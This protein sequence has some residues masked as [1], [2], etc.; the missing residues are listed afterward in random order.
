MC[1]TSIPLLKK[2]VDKASVQ[3]EDHKKEWASNGFSIMFDGW[4]DSVVQKVLVNFLVNSPRGSV[5]MKSN[6]VLEVVKDVNLLFNML[7]EMVE[8]VREQKGCLSCNR[9]QTM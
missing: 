5:F 4:R 7:D 2:E 8:E 3:V 1:S 6:E 9:H